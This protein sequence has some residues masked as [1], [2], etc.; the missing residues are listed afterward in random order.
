MTQVVPDKKAFE[1]IEHWLGNNYGGEVGEVEEGLLEL[2][3]T[4]VRI[5]K[6]LKESDLL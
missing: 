6:G 5:T 1:N 2:K 4:V 3:K